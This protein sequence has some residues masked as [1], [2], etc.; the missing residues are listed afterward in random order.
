MGDLAR[1]NTQSL[2]NRP[3]RGKLEAVGAL[4]FSSV[5][6]AGADVRDRS[7]PKEVQRAGDQPDTA[8]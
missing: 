1:R 3:W 8:K 4:N 6:A 2:T 7:C 5:M